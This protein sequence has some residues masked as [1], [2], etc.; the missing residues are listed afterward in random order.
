MAKIGW[1]NVNA[2]AKTHPVG[3]KLK[4]PWGLYDM[5]GNVWE[6]CHDLFE[7]NPKNPTASVIDPVGM[8]GTSPVFRG[9]CW[10][11]PAGDARAA[12][13]YLGSSGIHKNTIG[14]RL[15]RSVP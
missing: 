4:N 1:Y 11:N 13:R 5:A 7:T 15:A 12:R 8:V 2:G 6:W 10:H 14:F 3:K 9:G